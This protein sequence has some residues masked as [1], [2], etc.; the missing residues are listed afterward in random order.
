M[1]ILTIHPMSTPRLI[2]FFCSAIFMS[3]CSSYQV[4]NDHSGDIGSYSGATLNSPVTDQNPHVGG[5]QSY[6]TSH[7]QGRQQVAPGKTDY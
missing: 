1:K 5:D 2:L 3:G 4:G 7:D 6:P